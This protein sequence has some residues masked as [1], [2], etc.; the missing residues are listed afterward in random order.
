MA[1]T[2]SGRTKGTRVP[3]LRWKRGLCAAA[4]AAALTGAPLLARDAVA[5]RSTSIQAA[6]YVTTS[7]LGARFTSDTTEVARAGA[8]QPAVRRLPLEGLG[9]LD[10]QTG[11]GVQVR[12]GPRATEPANRS[13]VVIQI[14]YVS[15]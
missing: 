13:T 11:P 12:V 15:T 9:V 6:A 10:V 1:T 8:S 5:Q 3:D 2:S 7:Y 4:L 14:A